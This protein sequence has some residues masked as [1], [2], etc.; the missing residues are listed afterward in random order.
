MAHQLSKDA[1]SLLCELIAAD[2]P[3]QYLCDRFT[4]LSFSEDE[5]LRR[6]IREL[7]D[8]GFID[9]PLWADNLPYH[10]S[11]NGA[12]YAYNEEQSVQ[13]HA[14]SVTIIN[15]NSIN[16][17]DN[18]I[19]RKSLIGKMEGEVEKT[20]SNKQPFHK[21][22]PWITAIV[23]SLIAGLILMFSFWDKIVAFLEGV[24]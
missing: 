12:A 1:K 14:S 18:N 19:I 17:G 7:K 2:N 8:E 9:I 13:G 24:F 20:T 5:K 22:H 23:A 15:D 10:V 11:I 6:L 4:D 21:R 16:I 3:T